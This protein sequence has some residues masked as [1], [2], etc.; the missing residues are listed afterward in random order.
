MCTNRFQNKDLGKLRNDSN[1]DN[2]DNI[3]EIDVN[4]NIVKDD[5]IDSDSLN[6]RNNIDNDTNNEN[7]DNDDDIVKGDS[8][9][10]RSHVLELDSF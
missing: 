6:Y 4:N 5:A 1:N 2:D 3:N 10:V 8:K 9:L 7:N